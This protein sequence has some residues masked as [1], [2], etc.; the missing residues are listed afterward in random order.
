MNYE[1]MIMCAINLSSAITNETKVVL[2]DWKFQTIPLIFLKSRM[3]H[4]HFESTSSLFNI[5]VTK[6]HMRE[7]R[8]QRIV[9]SSYYEPFY[10]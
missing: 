10:C 9:S 6:F 2:D 3:E 1:A 8:C 4:S 5:K 7:W